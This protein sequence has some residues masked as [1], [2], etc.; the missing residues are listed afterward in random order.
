MTTLTVARP[1]Q[2]DMEYEFDCP[3]FQARVARRIQEPGL[4][5]TL[6]EGLSAQLKN[7]MVWEG[8]TLASEHDST[9]VPTPDQ[10][11][12]LDAA[13]ARFKCVVAV[14][15]MLCNIAYFA[16]AKEISAAVFFTKV[17]G[18]GPAEQALNFLVLPSAFGN[19]LATLIGASR[20]IQV[21]ILVMLWWP[22]EG[23]PYAGSVTFWY[24]TYCVV[25]IATI[26]PEILEVS[27]NGTNT[28]RLVQVPLSELG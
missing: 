13:L 23:G 26:R 22:P 11:D 24:A 10:L 9:C 20:L 3:K 27:D 15:Y 12:E 8:A 18:S 25:G 2:P 16:A 21:Y 7:D 28:H 6:P 1:V 14:L 17:F 19:L 4:P 5:K